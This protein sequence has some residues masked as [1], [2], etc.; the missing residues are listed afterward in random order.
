MKLFDPITEGTNDKSKDL[1]VNIDDYEFILTDGY[2]AGDNL[3]FGFT[4]NFIKY[5]DF[6]VPQVLTNSDN[7]AI[8]PILVI[9]KFIGGKQLVGKMINP[10]RFVNHNN[11]SV[12]YKYLIGIHKSNWDLM[13]NDNQLGQIT[14]LKRGT[15]D[16]NLYGYT[17]NQI[18]SL[19]QQDKMLMLTDSRDVLSYKWVRFNMTQP[20]TRRVLASIGRNDNILTIINQNTPEGEV[21]E[22]SGL[23][24]TNGRPLVF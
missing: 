24:V 20:T 22:G 12:R 10:L 15:Y 23:Y 17:M 13:I 1:E 7:G 9:D 3:I 4:T 5:I 19:N 14:L 21:Y 11:Y 16:Y 6:I 8:H 18:T 2:D